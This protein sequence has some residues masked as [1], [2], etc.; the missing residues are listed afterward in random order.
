[1]TAAAGSSGST[2]GVGSV[3]QSG[4]SSEPR[5]GGVKRVLRAGGGVEP[6]GGDDLAEHAEQ[7]GA[8]LLGV[9]EALV[10]IGRG[11]PLEEGVQRGK[12]E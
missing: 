12:R 3:R 10:G 5:A 8:H 2:S 9:L 11:R 6:R 7:L 1:M 4:P